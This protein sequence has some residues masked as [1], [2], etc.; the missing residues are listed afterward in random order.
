MTTVNITEEKLI[1]LGNLCLSNLRK[2]VNDEYMLTFNVVKRL[3]TLFF[4]AC[5]K[6]FYEQQK[7]NKRKK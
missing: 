6:V 2:M 1:D 5:Q 4:L 3:R 7:K